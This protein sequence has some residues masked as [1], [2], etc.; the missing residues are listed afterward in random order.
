V[1]WAHTGLGRVVHPCQQ[2]ATAGP[3]E[4]SPGHIGLIEGILADPSLAHVNFDISWDEVA[5]YVV[6]TPTSLQRTVD[7]INRHPDRLLFGTD[8]VAPTDQPGYLKVF[9]MY[10]PLWNLLSEDASE[11]VRK[12]N[13]ERLFAEE[14]RRVR[15]W[16]KTNLQ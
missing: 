15:A 5:K 14:G 7:L 6:A 1:I 8:E 10:G 12:C 2:Q 9:T 16:E 11:K 13:N 4:R 3:A